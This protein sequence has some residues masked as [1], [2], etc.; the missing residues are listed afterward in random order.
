[1]AAQQ[2]RLRFAFRLRTVDTAH[3]LHRRQFRQTVERGRTAGELAPR[4]SNLLQA[5]VL[6]PEAHEVKLVPPRYKPGSRRDPTGLRNKK[7]AA[8]EFRVWELLL[9]DE[10]TVVY[11]DGSEKWQDGQHLV[12]YGFAVYGKGSRA[13]GFAHIGPYT[14]VFDAEVIGALRGL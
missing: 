3:P 14:Y 6:L 10:N 13:I 4:S 8:M 1:M 9:G 11:T 12:G 2:A 7:A 5:C